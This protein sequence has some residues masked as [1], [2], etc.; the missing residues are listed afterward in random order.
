MSRS[1]SPRWSCRSACSCRRHPRSETRAEAEAEVLRL[2]KEFLLERDRVVYTD[3]PEG[4]YPLQAEAGRDAH[5]LTVENTDLAWI[6][7]RAPE[8]T[9]VDEGL[10]E[11]ADLLG[12]AER[13]AELRRA[14]VI[15][16]AAQRV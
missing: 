5:Q 11:D 16:F 2:V 13:E 8:R 6:V 3:R 4:R 1:T 14:G 9:D 12:Q 10:A 7:G 15:V